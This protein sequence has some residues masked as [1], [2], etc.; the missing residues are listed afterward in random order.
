MQLEKIIIEKA[1]DGNYTCKILNDNG[2][3]TYIY[4]K[5][6]PLE[7]IKIDNIDARKNHILLGLGLG[8]ELNLLLEKTDKDIYVFD[9]NTSFYEKILENNELSF[10]LKNNR[11]KFYFGEDYLKISK[12]LL[13]NSIIINNFNITKFNSDYFLKIINYQLK[14]TPIKKSF[15][16]VLFFEHIT[17]ADDCI[18]ALKTLGFDVVKKKI[19]SE[20]KLVEEIILEQP[21]FIFTINLNRNLYELCEKLNLTY[22]AWV[23]DTPYY[24]L[25]EKKYTYKNGFIFIYDEKISEE[26]NMKG[27][28]NVFYL[29]VAVNVTRLDKITISKEDVEKYSTDISFVGSSGKNNEYNKFI[30]YNLSTES[31]KLVEN[32]LN[33]QKKFSDKFIIKD[34]IDESL[35]NIIEK[36]ANYTILSEELLTKKMKLA[37]LLGRKYNELE[38]IIT[39]NFLNNYFNLDVYGDDTWTPL[40]SGY[41]GYAEHFTE[42]PKIFRLSKI[43]LNITRIYVDSGLPMRVFDVLGS[44]GF[45]VTNYK[46]DLSKF[47]IDGK[48][49]IIYRDL[50]D[51]K[52]ISEFYV[53]HE[54]EREEIINQGYLKVKKEHT[55]EVRLKE[56]MKIVTNN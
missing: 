42:M 6:K 7:N 40:I 29:P 49:L 2:G 20:K 34:Y 52:D 4:S 54:L 44:K 48:E 53:N 19:S 16:K 13:M 47:F 27:C 30:E 1:K 11:V 50:K 22:I 45:L 28:K 5:Y 15:K 41:N 39:L 10:I 31:R 12:E 3:Y 8:Y 26:L 56:I 38:R 25:Y 51:L 46:D 21:D 17:I 55:F 9:K 33:K 23:V 32:I 35:I 43:N 24:A 14:L 18:D 36:E 37:F